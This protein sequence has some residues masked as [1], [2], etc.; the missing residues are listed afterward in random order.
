MASTNFV[1]S[2]LPAYVQTNR[3]LIIKSFALVGTDTRRRIGLQTGVKGKAYL[4]YLDLAPTLQDGSDCGFD[5]AGAITLTQRTVETA[6]I[7]AQD[8]ICPR[9]L[10]GTYAEYLVRINA[11]EHDLPFEQYIIDTLVAQINKKI[12]KLIWQGDTSSA[13]TNLKWIDG[14]L[15]QMGA[16]ADVIPESIASGSTAYEGILQVYMSMPEE[17]LE[18]GGVIFVSPA[19][20]RSFLQDLVALNYFHYAGAVNAAPEEFILPGSDVRV[21]KTPGL[22]GSLEI[23]GTFEKNLVYACDMENDNEDID[24]WF[25]Q[26]DRVFK[27]EVLWKI[28][29]A[30]CRER[31]SPRV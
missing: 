19:I 12:E 5:A 28:G 21:I 13:D 17:T 27:Y 23:V 18:R 31:V 25:S 22:A 2:S 6:L 26:D 15:V 20:Y 29:R 9:S 1:V 14:F 24:L 7:A 30:S 11:T 16:D 10:V 4:N 3:D 8:D